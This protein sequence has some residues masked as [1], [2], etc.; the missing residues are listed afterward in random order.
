MPLSTYICIAC[1][2]TPNNPDMI[3]SYR[4]AKNKTTTPITT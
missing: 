2:I 1:M 4:N 3:F